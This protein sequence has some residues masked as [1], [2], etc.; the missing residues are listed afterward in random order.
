MPT[1]LDIDDDRGKLHLIRETFRDADVS[2]QTARTASSGLEQIAESHPDR[3]LLDVMLPD[4]RGIE[5]FENLNR[6][7]ARLPVIF[8]TAGGTSDTAI[9]AMIGGA[10]DYLVKPLDLERVRELV[11]QALEMR[12]LMHVPVQLPGAPGAEDD[13]DSMI[14]RSP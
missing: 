10:Y 14:G 11:K 8:I 5:A 3:V 7:D 6:L 9:E 13:A 2:V 1:T 4:M 12:R